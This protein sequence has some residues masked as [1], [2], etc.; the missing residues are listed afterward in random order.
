[1][2]VSQKSDSARNPGCSSV[3][4]SLDVLRAAELRLLAT[5]P[6][7]D[8]DRLGRYASLLMENLPPKAVILC[9]LDNACM[10]I[11]THV[12]ASGPL[13]E[14]VKYTEQIVPMYQ[15]AGASCAAVLFAPCAGEYGYTK[16][17]ERLASQ[18]TLYCRRQKLRLVECVA[19]WSGGYV[20][21]YRQSGYTFSL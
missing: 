8:T 11:E 16:E 5:Q 15:K 13:A 14:A 4:F 20:P 17:D 7:T 12:L 9:L 19:A 6:F 21:L 10:L 2:P 1:M 3:T 18:I